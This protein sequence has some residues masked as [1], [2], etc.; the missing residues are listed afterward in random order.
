M[1]SLQ[2]PSSVPLVRFLAS[3]A[4]ALTNGDMRNSYFTFAFDTCDGVNTCTGLPCTDVSCNFSL[5]PNG[6]LFPPETLDAESLHGT[7]AGV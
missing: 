2:D 4:D 5:S 6:D 1:F 7:I 3:D